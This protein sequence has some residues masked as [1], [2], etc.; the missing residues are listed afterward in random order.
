MKKEE[1][2]RFIDKFVVFLHKLG[3]DIAKL[4][5]GTHPRYEEIVE[6]FK[7]IDNEK[8][9]KQRQE[10]FSKCSNLQLEYLTSNSCYPTSPTN[11]T[12]GIIYLCVAAKDETKM[13]FIKE[14]NNIQALTNAVI[15]KGTWQKL[16]ELIK[17]H[18]SIKWLHCIGHGGQKLC[19]TIMSF[20]SV[21]ENGNLH[22]IADKNI[23]EALRQRSN[24]LELV[25]F[26]SCQS[27]TLVEEIT[28]P[29]GIKYSWGWETKCNDSAAHQLARKFYYYYAHGTSTCS[30]D[31]E[32]AMSFLKLDTTKQNE[33]RDGSSISTTTYKIGDPESNIRVNNNVNLIIAG[34][35][36]F[37]K[38]PDSPFDTYINTL[39]KTLLL[40]QFEISPEGPRSMVEIIERFQQYL[41]SR[42]SD[43][44]HTTVDELVKNFF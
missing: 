23:I 13:E 41:K 4:R 14:A 18:K 15:F 2:Y 42:T 32:D 25:S 5:G 34:I 24:Q 27:S 12:T 21:D 9:Y 33:L 30:D 8:F 10:L 28:K 3:R 38:C 44:G 35:P 6:I 40:H 16:V 31:F 1:A 7:N 39:C 17:Q 43:L 20:Q 19:D 36:I 11:D 22:V 29:G 26:N 37:K